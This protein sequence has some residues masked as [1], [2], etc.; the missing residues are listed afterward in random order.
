MDF[1]YYLVTVTIPAPDYSVGNDT[2]IWE[3]C[4]K[5]GFPKIV[6]WDQTPPLQPDENGHY[7]VIYQG[8]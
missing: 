3:L 7:P 8:M 2:C 5:F 4:Y 6:S 1:I